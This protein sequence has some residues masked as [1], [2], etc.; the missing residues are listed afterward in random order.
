MEEQRAK[1]SQPSA[2]LAMNLVIAGPCSAESEAQV[3]QTA[4]ELAAF[5][6]T[7][8]RAGVWKPRTRPGCFEGCGEAALPWLQRV[9]S[10]LGMK[11]IIEVATPEHVELALKY[12]I[13]SFWIGARTTANPFAVQAIA[14]EIRQRLPFPDAKEDS[15]LMVKN[16]MNP[17]IDLWVGAIERLRESG[18]KHI[19]AVHRGFSTYEKTQYRNQPMWQLPM[20]FRR[21]MPDVPLYCDPSHIGG[22]REL[23]HQLS[24]QALDLG[25]DGLM[26][27]S[28]CR[29]ECALSDAEQ[30]L[31]P[32]ELHEML[33]KLIVRDRHSSNEGLD[34]L[35]KQI[36]S[37]D[38]QL[39]DIIAR[40]MGISREIGLYKKEHNMTVFQSN[41]YK[42]V[43][44]RLVADA[45]ERGIDASCIKT[46]F[47]AIHEESVRQQMF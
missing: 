40:R 11:V 37:L 22:R 10:E 33:G 25:F 3:M 39:I 20:D 1:A 24:Q 46:I 2:S 8:F 34:I 47:E 9:Q 23:V 6:I 21:R 35:R 4:T 38:S 43:L 41:R 36:D 14:D 13:T 5:G 16:P 12:G 30:Q 45:N 27:E 26:I 15:L 29:P 19:V 17:D 18:I 42:Q 7:K 28:H 32:L 31:T 44:E